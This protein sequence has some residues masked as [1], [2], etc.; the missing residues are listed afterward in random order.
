MNPW[1]VYLG[2]FYKANKSKM[3]YKQAMKVARESYKKSGAS[4][5]APATKKRRSSK[6]RGKK[7]RKT[8]SNK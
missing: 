6:K 2:K 3:S 4:S 7:G 1:I 5:V 8:R